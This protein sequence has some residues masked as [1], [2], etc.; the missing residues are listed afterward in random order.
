MSTFPNVN[1]PS[2]APTLHILTLV[3]NS[4][5]TVQK[6]KRDNYSNGKG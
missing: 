5:K 6:E 2:R 1:T 3:V 4:T